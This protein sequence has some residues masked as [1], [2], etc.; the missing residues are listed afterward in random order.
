MVK[1]NSKKALTK[2]KGNLSITTFFRSVKAA[3]TPTVVSREE[4]TSETS[5]ETASSAQARD[6]STNKRTTRTTHTASRT[7]AHSTS[8]V[9]PSPV[10][11]NTYAVTVHHDAVH[12]D[13][14]FQ[15]KPLREKFDAATSD[16]DKATSRMDETPHE[17]HSIRLLS[18]KLSKQTRDMKRH[19]TDKDETRPE[20]NSASS[21][22]PVPHNSTSSEVPV[23]DNSTS[24]IVRVPDDSI[25]LVAVSDWKQKQTQHENSSTSHVP[26]T[27][28]KKKH[29]R[30]DKD[31]TPHKNNSTEPKQTRDKKRR[32]TTD[33]KPPPREYIPIEYRQ[34]TYIFPLP[35]FL[36]NGMSATTFA[37]QMYTTAL[38]KMNFNSQTPDERNQMLALCTILEKLCGLMSVEL[39]HNPAFLRSKIRPLKGAK[40]KLQGIYGAVLNASQGLVKIGMTLDNARTRLKRQ[41]H[42]FA[43]KLMSLPEAREWIPKEIVEEIMNL[44]LPGLKARDHRQEN[45]RDLVVLQLAEMIISCSHETATGNVCERLT[46]MPLGIVRDILAPFRF[47]K[48]MLDFVDGPIEDKSITALLAWNTLIHHLRNHRHTSKF[49]EERVTPFPKEGGHFVKEHCALLALGGA[50]KEWVDSVPIPPRVTEDLEP[51]VEAFYDLLKEESMEDVRGNV[52]LLQAS[53]DKIASR[54]VQTSNNVAATEPNLA[55]GAVN[56]MTRLFDTLGGREAL[57]TENHTFCAVAENNKSFYNKHFR[58]CERCDIL[59]KRFFIVKCNTDGRTVYVTGSDFIAFSESVTLMQRLKAIRNLFVKIQYFAAKG[60][61]SAEYVDQVRGLL[62]AYLMAITF[63]KTDADFEARRDEILGNG[64]SSAAESTE[65]TWAILSNEEDGMED[66]CEEED[67]DWQEDALPSALVSDET[68]T[69]RTARWNFLPEGFCPYVCSNVIST[70]RAL[71]M[72]VYDIIYLKWKMD[73]LQNGLFHKFAVTRGLLQN[74]NETCLPIDLEWVCPG[75]D[76]DHPCRGGHQPDATPSLYGARGRRNSIF[77]KQFVCPS[78]HKC[79]PAIELKIL[80]EAIDNQ[81]PLSPLE[82]IRYGELMK[83]RQNANASQQKYWNELPAETKLAKTRGDSEKGSFDNRQAFN[84]KKS[85]QAKERKAQGKKR[86]TSSGSC[87]NHNFAGP[88]PDSVQ[89]KLAQGINLLMGKMRINELAKLTLNKLCDAIVIQEYNNGN[90]ELKSFDEAPVVFLSDSDETKLA[91]R[92]TNAYK[93]AAEEFGMKEESRSFVRIERIAGKPSG[94][95]ADVLVRQVLREL[96]TT[97]PPGP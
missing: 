68:N 56:E 66:V 92:H 35:P 64:P 49:L 50:M 79:G 34:Q 31:E 52:D 93:M 16:D 80:Q 91:K 70:A 17:N 60:V 61:H 97:A 19:R 32:R 53:S 47:S 74:P 21:Q 82:R 78:C 2:P 43:A 25:S 51:V 71:N 89:N 22:V 76:P 81:R 73:L 45:V 10:P 15:G 3:A 48:A 95:K 36:G 39:Q 8:R 44:N 4:P 13:E 7:V 75:L 41:H 23:P 20:N 28:D 14:P 12:D 88:Y 55:F 30:T 87:R 77:C 5:D 84:K 63:D 67:T 90:P 96:Y 37:Q 86:K 59:P 1:R 24:S 9:T 18:V 72:T 57:L 11:H 27:R 85:D 33:R 26:V 6:E 94:T 42:Q 83:G 58:Q 62:L 65:D 38:N 46:Q 54:L 29:P 69:F 40:E